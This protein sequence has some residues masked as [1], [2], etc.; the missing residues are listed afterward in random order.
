[1]VKGSG[2]PRIDGVAIGE[3]SINLLSPTVHLTAKYALINSQTAERFGAGNRNSNWSDA[4]LTKLGELIEAM[5][6]DVCLEVFTGG[7][8]EVAPTTDGVHEPE[9]PNQSDD[10]QIPSL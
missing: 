6:N 3:V 10:D 8:G 5:E 9:L 7:V 4:T 1:M 2:I